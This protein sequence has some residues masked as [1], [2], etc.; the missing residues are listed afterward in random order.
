[1]TIKN[2]RTWIALV[3][4]SAVL[5]GCG[6]TNGDGTTT[7]IRLLNASPDLG[8]ASLYTDSDQRA[9]NVA[10]D[11]VSGYA[12]F[13]PGTYTV[14]LTSSIGITLA[15]VSQDLD[16]NTR[17][18]AVAW[19]RSG[20]TNL[21]VLTEA[22][23]DTD[24]MNSGWGRLRVFNGAGNEAGSLDV[25]LLPNSSGG[26]P[27]LSTSTPA[28]AGT[29]TT[30]TA[31]SDLLAGTYRLVVT[32]ANDPSDV[33]L[34]MPS[35]TLGNQQLLTL[36]LEPSAS[37]VLV[38][39]LLLSHQGS[40]TVAKNTGARIRVIASAPNSGAVTVTYGSVTLASSVS[41]PQMGAYQLVTAGSDL[42][43]ATVNGTTASPVSTVS[44]FLPGTDY[45]LLV[46]GPSSMPK[47]LAVFDDN[48][49][50]T[51]SAKAKIRLL[52][53]YASA[54]GAASLT[55]DS[56][57][58]GPAT[59]APGATDYQLIAP[60]STASVSVTA[61]STS[62]LAPVTNGTP[63]RAA[64]VYTVYILDGNT[65][66]DGTTPQPLGLTRSQR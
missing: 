26:T 28:L 31:Y 24:G 1:M 14:K 54:I 19:G 25:Y 52:N 61:G 51:N 34:D 29:T 30:V 16:K 32:A 9:G 8:A 18:T 36:V 35:F 23:S 20:A 59:A 66:S 21:T 46:T 58:V 10:P 15:S 12:E 65:A 41:S 4:L 22:D 55:V 42:V 49:L 11:T 63:L 13:D 44:S 7:H 56:V 62:L 50:P 39:A 40:L 47:V 38:H 33:R 27:D 53:G 5:A 37:G 43:T 60:D 57:G 48:R 45:T 64:S 3:L 2:L 6:G 17:Y